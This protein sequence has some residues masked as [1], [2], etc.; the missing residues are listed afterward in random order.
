MSSTPT[1]A[2]ANSPATVWRD[3]FGPG[4][5]VGSVERAVQT[6]AAAALKPYRGRR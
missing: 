5:A 1:T 2:S 6:V 3:A 4:F